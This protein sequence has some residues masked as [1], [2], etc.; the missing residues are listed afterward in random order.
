MP[1]TPE[2]AGE[3]PAYTPAVGELVWDAARKRVGEV[4]DHRWSRYQ[5]RPPGGGIEWHAEPG[6]VRPSGATRQGQR[7]EECSRIKSAYYAASRV[8]DRDGAARWTT[9]M[10]LHQW[11]AH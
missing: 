2:Q 6:D 4:M 10:G 5:L 9:A 7:C 1:H 8:G 3:A 11:A